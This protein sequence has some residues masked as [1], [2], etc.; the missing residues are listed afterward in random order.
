MSKIPIERAKT[1]HHAEYQILQFLIEGPNA[2]LNG[3]QDLARQMGAD[4][5]ES[6]DPI[7]S[8]AHK[9]FKTGMKEIHKQ[10]SR[11]LAQRERKITGDSK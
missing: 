10:L 8:V 5:N 6:G 1:R 4:V 9:R 3:L 7:D 11:L 2:N